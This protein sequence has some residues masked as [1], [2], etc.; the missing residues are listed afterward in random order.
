M[1]VEDGDV[2]DRLLEATDGVVATM[3]FRVIRAG[4]EQRCYVIIKQKA[5]PQHSGQDLNSKILY[6]RM[7]NS[8]SW[9]S[10]RPSLARFL[11]VF[12]TSTLQL[13][14]SKVVEANYLIHP[15]IKHH[16]IAFILTTGYTHLKDRNH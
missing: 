15:C 4:K 5:S 6:T 1:M 11:C 13:Y 3:A 9:K 8:G 7:I 12:L 10:F 16:E 2:Q 14:Y